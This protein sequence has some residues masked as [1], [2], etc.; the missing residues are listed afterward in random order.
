MMPGRLL[1][2]VLLLGVASGAH[3]SGTDSARTDDH[4]PSPRLALALGGGGARGIA[5]IGALRALEEAGIPVDAIAG[6][7]MGAVV[8]G[9]YA[10]GRTAEELD[11]IILSVD[12]G[13]L[14]SG[15][16]DRRTLPVAR[17]QDRFGTFAGVD[18]GWHELALAGGL[19]GEH[20]INRF[21]IQQLAPADYAAGGDFGRLAIPFRCV[22]TALDDGARVVLGRGDLALAVRAS[23]SIPILL[24]PVEWEGRRLV[25]GL[26]V[27]NLPVDVARG[28]GAP[29]VVAVDVETLPLEADEYRS[30]L[31]VA[32]QISDL[33][34][35]RRNADFAQE[36]DVVVRPDLGEHPATRYS[37][38]DTL[39]ARGYEAMQAALPEIRGKLQAAGLDD[40]LPP[41]TPPAPQRTLDG[42]PVVKVV[43][44]GD[45][46]IDEPVL[47]RAFDMPI[48]PGFALEKG[49]RA[50][51]R[52]EA[53]GLVEHAWMDFEPTPEG[54]RIGLVV[55]EAAPNRAEI[56]AAFTEWEKARGV[57][58]LLNRDTLGFGEETSLLLVASEADVG[59]RLG[60]R[61]DFPFLPGVGYRVD[62]YLFRDKPRFFDTEGEKINRA[63][64]ERGGLDAA[65][66]VS[67][68]GWGLLEA[69]L[70]L[71]SVTTHPK[72]GLILPAATD[73]GRILL[74]GVVVDTLD[75]L[76]WPESGQRLA[77]HGWWNVRD[78]GATRPFWRLRGEGRLGQRLGDRAVV[79]LDALVGL[80]DDR[81]PVYD[82]FRVGGPYLIPGYRH[83]QLKGPQAL[84]G[85]GSLRFRVFGQLQALARVGAGN[86]FPSRDRLGFDE[87]RWGVGVGLMYPSG[88]GP[89]AV[90]LG[91]RDGGDSVVSVSLGWN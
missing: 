49:L 35:E 26:V 55:R 37:D 61:G 22:A 5:H 72:P 29:V 88:V 17:R 21:L 45:E 83:E 63:D 65:L 53:S 3:G 66:Q 71:G 2:V 1:A 59:A 9:I 79:Q 36:P 73:Q 34:S 32:E 42:A 67:L 43:V 77:V 38:F 14:F 85:A 44:R 84:A 30:A 7:S 80:S 51:D 69:G 68:R 39:I 90:E 87:L 6:T 28:F 33:L 23:M 11:K 60:L 18:F 41:R 48:G 81:V 25:D 75:N 82:W 31:G 12:W 86:V 54:L 89:L 70:R 50:L 15:R 91:W 78:L 8:G 58:H 20:R 13:T 24:P 56:G 40:V 19:L 62:G 10:T 27:D 47:R 64:F 16:P 4:R 52:V 76:L 74:A 46:R 57:L